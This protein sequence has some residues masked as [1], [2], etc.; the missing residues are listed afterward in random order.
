MN[1]PFR[2]IRAFIDHYVAQNALHPQTISAGILIPDWHQTRHPAL[3]HMQV[4]V[5]FTKG[6]P[7]FSQPCQ[8]TRQ[9]RLSVP[10]GVK[11]Y[12]KPP[13]PS[14]YTTMQSADNRLHMGFGHHG[15]LAF[16]LCSS[17]CF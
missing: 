12:Y 14:V 6:W 1:P 3:H 17:T 11:G 16:S 5:Q 15:D 9:H 4:V 13:I 2:N 7:L 8:G 10:W